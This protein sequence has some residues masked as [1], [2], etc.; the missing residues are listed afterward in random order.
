MTI[1]LGNLPLEQ[2]DVVDADVHDIPRSTC[3]KS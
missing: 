3:G 2:V 1:E